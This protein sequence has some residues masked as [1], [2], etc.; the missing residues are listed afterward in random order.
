MA[1]AR[2][3]AELLQKIIA[4]YMEDEAIFASPSHRLQHTVRL[5]LINRRLRAFT[6]SIPSIWQT[7]YLQWPIEAVEEYLRRAQYSGISLYLD[8]FH[9]ADDQKKADAKRQSWAIILRDHMTAF[10]SLDIHI[11]TAACGKALS[12]ALETPAPN[13][14]TFHLDLGK[15]DITR[16][17][18]SLQA[19]NLQ[20]V[21]LNTRLAWD[22]APFTSL[23]S[24]TLTV[25]QENSRK[26]LAML[27]T[28]DQLSALSLTGTNNTTDIPFPRH[29]HSI[30]LPPCQILKLKNMTSLSTRRLMSTVDLPQLQALEINEIV[31]MSD[32]ESVPTTIPDA[33]AAISGPIVDP[34]S[35]SIEIYHER[36]IIRTDGTP[37]ISYTSDWRFLSKPARGDQR[38]LDTIAAMIDSVSNTLQVAYM[39][40]ELPPPSMFDDLDLMILF[41]RVF[42]DYPL[43]STLELSGHVDQALFAI[44]AG[45]TLLDLSYLKLS[46]LVPGAMQIFR[47]MVEN[48]QLRRGFELHIE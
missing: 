9:G 10:E 13:L 37:S 11:R 42:R 31:A 16:K 26:I 17:L 1:F 15:F 5:G 14:K 38:I 12:M 34:E 43:I 19:P 7:I 24:V 36:V 48:L 32:L 18:F 45:G 6:L 29:P 33:F 4:E 47:D 3:P 22:L 21:H 20:T 8:T 44:D 41:F 27:P 28:M 25:C 39:Y 46:N 35:L 40:L 2:T 30:V 23:S